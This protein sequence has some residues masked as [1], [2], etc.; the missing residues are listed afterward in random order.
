MRRRAGAMAGAR[1]CTSHSVRRITYASALACVTLAL[2]HSKRQGAR[3]RRRSARPSA[4]AAAR[5]A[6]LAPS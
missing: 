4:P 1:G 2:A 6:V 5:S 3:R